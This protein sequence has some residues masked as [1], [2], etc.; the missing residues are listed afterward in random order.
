MEIRIIKKVVASIGLFQK[1][2]WTQVGLLTL[3]FSNGIFLYLLVEK[4]SH[5]LP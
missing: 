5:E 3:D 4:E 2:D 1:E